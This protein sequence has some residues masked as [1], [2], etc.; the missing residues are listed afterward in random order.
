MKYHL[1]F[2]DEAKKKRGS[3]AQKHRGRTAVQTKVR[4]T[5]DV[6]HLIFLL[7]CFPD[8]KLP[9]KNILLLKGGSGN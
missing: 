5:P 7:D 4:S 9:Q 8:Q 2:A 3:L 6:K 1:H